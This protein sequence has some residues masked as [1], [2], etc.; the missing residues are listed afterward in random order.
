MGSVR[1]IPTM[2]WNSRTAMAMPGPKILKL[3]GLLA[4]DASNPQ[5]RD[6]A[7]RQLIRHR[8][9]IFEVQMLEFGGSPWLERRRTRWSQLPVCH[10][11]L[12][13]GAPS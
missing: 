11:K 13:D 12:L 3:D 4:Y 8:G 2:T 6:E 10:G 5:G 1:F 7:G 9:P